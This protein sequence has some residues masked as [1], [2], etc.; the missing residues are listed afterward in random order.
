LKT[1]ARGA[2]RE[3]PEIIVRRGL[4]LE[5]DSAARAKVAAE[6]DA[7]AT[8]FILDLGRYAD[9]HVFGKAAETFMARVAS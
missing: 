2:G 5:D 6:K 7:G 9:E 1:Q 4:K 3:L 8:Y